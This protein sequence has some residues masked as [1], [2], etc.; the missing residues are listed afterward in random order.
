MMFSRSTQYGASL[1]QPRRIGDAD[2]RDLRDL[3][4]VVMKLSGWILFFIGHRMEH[5]KQVSINAPPCSVVWF[6][7]SWD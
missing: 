3:F 7:L 1:E 2:L 4:S 6:V 5:H